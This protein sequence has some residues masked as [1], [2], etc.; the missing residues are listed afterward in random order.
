MHRTGKGKSGVLTFGKETLKEQKDGKPSPPPGSPY[1]IAQVGSACSFFP[2]VGVLQGQDTTA[3]TGV[4]DGE[5][6]RKGPGLLL[7]ASTNSPRNRQAS[8]HRDG[9]RTRKRDDERN[10]LVLTLSPCKSLRSLSSLARTFALHRL[11]VL[12]LGAGVETEE[13]EVSRH[14][15]PVKDRPSLINALLS[16]SLNLQNNPEN[17]YIADEEA[18]SWS[19]EPSLTHG[20]LRKARLCFLRGKLLQILCKL[21]SLWCEICACVRAHVYL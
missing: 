10:S 14:L 4:W 17:K 1:V 11:L 20:Q 6:R 9:Q 21:E 8:P 7:M 5:A 19:E 2:S 13:R 12:P 15:C 3:R 18:E 16:P